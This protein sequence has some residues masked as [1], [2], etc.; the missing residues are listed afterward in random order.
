[1]AAHSLPT[2]GSL[3]PAEVAERIRLYNDRGTLQRGLR[4]F[5]DA[6]AED[7]RAVLRKQIADSMQT[8][9][10]PDYGD[11]DIQTKIELGVRSA[12]TK[13]TGAIDEDWVN[14]ACLYGTY[15]HAV[16]I[17]SAQVAFE[18]VQRTHDMIAMIERRFAD[19]IERMKHFSAITHRLAAFEQEIAMKQMAVL[20]TG[21]ARRERDQ[22]SEIFEADVAAELSLALADSASLRLDCE[23]TSGAARQTLE[24]ALQVATAATQSSSAMSEA[25][26]TA[27]NLAASI[28]EV[29]HQM[30]NATRVFDVAAEQSGRAMRSSRELSEEVGSIESI[31]GFIRDIAGQTNLLAL[32]ATIE[33][34]RAGDAGRG[35]AVVAQEVKSLANQTARATD[36]IA[37]KIAAI[38]AATMNTV[39]ANGEIKLTVEEM[40]ATAQ[41]V[42]AALQDQTERVSIIAA[43]VDETARTADSISETVGAI[44]TDA[45]QM[46]ANVE[47]LEK[48]SRAVDMRL[49][50]MKTRTGEFL[51]SFAGG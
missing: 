10:A 33:A 48:G 36:D 4:E 19:D 21:A 50:D 16:G 12:E 34:A 11:V 38:Q 3:S 44:R 41:K 2:Q 26:S 24:R 42:Y 23:N 37:A 13:Y 18:F 14:G 40:Q 31:L 47:R 49:A 20:A 5:W 45:A 22:V 43:S 7:I 35:F 32:N 51:A 27:A 1:M 30:E 8:M 29:G 28:S 39:G 6:C 15:Y 9:A 17:G 25:A 46:A